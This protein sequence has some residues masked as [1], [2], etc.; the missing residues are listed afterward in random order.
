MSLDHAKQC[1]IDKLQSDAGFRE[2][3]AD[4][5]TSRGFLYTSDDLQNSRSKLMMECSE[6]YAKPPKRALLPS[7]SQHH[8]SKH[9][10]LFADSLHGYEYWVG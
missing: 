2:R 8:D 5:I 7:V 10:Y 6:N 3:V 1:I 4:F 9:Q